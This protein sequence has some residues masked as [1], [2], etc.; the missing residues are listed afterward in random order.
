[1]AAHVLTGA[2]ESILRA[3]VSELIHQLVG[4]GDRSLMVDEFDGEEYQLRPV[5][6]AAQTP[7]FLTA[8]RVVL[9]RGVGRFTTDELVPLLG[10]LADPLPTTELVLVGGGGRI[11]KALTDAVKT[12]G[13]TVRDTAPPVRARDRQGWIS[14]EAATAGIRL[15]PA[16]MALIA[17][18]LGEDMG[19][20]DGIL[21]TLAA[22]YGNGRALGV[23]DVEPF[24]GEAGGVP[25]WELTDAVDA[26]DTSRAL[27]LLTRMTG[28]GG[29][30]P[31]QV[32]AVL[33][34]HYGRLARLDGTDV[35]SEV[36]AAEMLG[37]KPG[38]PV[39]KALQQY[40]RL[41]GGAVQRAVELLAAADI[42]LRGGRELPDEIV[43]E[44]LVARLSRLRR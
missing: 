30:H 25:P 5:V 40:R 10:Y 29:R 8:T 13:G 41:G 11:A 20:V 37:M 44:V 26:G 27:I 6:D 24:L 43:M 21:T 7:P 42:D 22:T 15:A 23:G 3:A 34:T 33:H 28:P 2:D 12:A 14:D 38:F 4:D 17:E 35:T 19:R 36:Q 18:R 31:L 9:A 1:M 32:M 39:K 16:A